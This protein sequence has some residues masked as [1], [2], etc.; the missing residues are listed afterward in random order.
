M[1]KCQFKKFRRKPGEKP[2]DY[3]TLEA[4]QRNYLTETRVIVSDSARRPSKIRIKN[5]P[6]G[7]A[8]GRS[9]VTVTREVTV[10]EGRKNLIV[11]CSLEKRTGIKAADIEGVPKK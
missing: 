2:G 5:C 10:E 4:T 11:V 6:L 9:L 7:F 3:S 8:T 1:T